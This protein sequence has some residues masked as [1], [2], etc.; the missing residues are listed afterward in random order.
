MQDQRQIA[1]G[2]IAVGVAGRLPGSV[3]PKHDGAAAILPLRD[4]S[5]KVAVIQ[6]MILDLHRQRLSSGFMTGPVRHRPALENAIQLQ[7]KIVV[8]PGR[9]VLLDQIGLTATSVRASRRRARPSGKV[10][11]AR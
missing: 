1:A 9:L 2:E 6:R 11:L 5:L 10:A 3:I 7:P 4:G 8:K